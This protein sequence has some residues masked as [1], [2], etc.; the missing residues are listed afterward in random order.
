MSVVV[1]GNPKPLSRTRAAAEL[2]ATKLT[3]SAPEHVID[4]V[5]LG[6][7]LLGWGDPKVAEAK[8]I[9]KAADLLVVASP[10]YKATYTGLLKLF[11]DQ[12]GAGELG[13]IPTVPLMLGGSPAHS[14]APE[15]TLRPVLVEIGASCPVPS[16]YLIDSEYETAPELDRWLEIARRVLA[17]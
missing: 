11:L 3:G 4:V 5:D 17:R 8:E 9:V 13:Q 7:A 2:V 12:F 15:L 14:L 10:T 1:V 6:A 16:L